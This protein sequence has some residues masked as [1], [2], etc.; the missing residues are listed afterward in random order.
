[1]P[2]PKFNPTEEQRRNGE[3]TMAACGTPHEQ[4]CGSDGN[5]FPQDSTETFPR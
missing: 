4:D 3:D 1:M 5:P 2:R